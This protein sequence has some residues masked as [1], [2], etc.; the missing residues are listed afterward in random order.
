MRY[1]FIINPTAHEGRAK[2]TWSQLKNYLDTNNI[3][4]NSNFTRY[5]GHATEIAQQLTTQA[6]SNTTVIVVG[7]DGTVDEAINGL[8][9]KKKPRT[10]NQLP[11][12]IIPAGWQNQ[13]AKS[14]NISETP[15]EAFQQI[16]HTTQE[17]TV[18]IGYYYESIKDE[19]GYFINSWGLGFDAALLSKQSEQKKGH[20]KM[21]PFSFIR[22]A[23][24]ILYN[25][26]PYSLMVQEKQQHLLFANTFISSCYNHLVKGTPEQ[27]HQSLLQPELSL[28]IVERHN[29]LITLWTL[30]LLLTGK[31]SKSR[32]AHL[33]TANQFHYTTT[34][35]EFVQKDGIELGN[36]FVDVTIESVP[37]QI[38]QNPTHT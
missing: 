38:W 15:I 16:S 6:S 7:G 28:L 13:F 22:N 5:P 2:N 21:G 29:W 35:L 9:I 12:A 18:Y 10:I 8:Y 19:A 3:E 36:R 4:Y 23:G 11:I 26:Q 20:R 31:I 32:W 24:S 17:S 25:Q 37:C 27:R 30:W 33:L 1:S 14:L 34:S